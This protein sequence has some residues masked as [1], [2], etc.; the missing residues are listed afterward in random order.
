MRERTHSYTDNLLFL[1]AIVVSVLMAVYT[2]G[3]MRKLSAGSNQDG[4]KTEQS[5]R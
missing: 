5:N 1:L 3:C 4:P 2:N